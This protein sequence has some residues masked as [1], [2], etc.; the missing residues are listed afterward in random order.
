MGEVGWRVGCG[1][2]AL[3]GLEGKEGEGAVAEEVCKVTFKMSIKMQKLHF[4]IISVISHSKM[5]T[6]YADAN[7]LCVYKWLEAHSAI[8]VGLHGV[9]TLVSASTLLSSHSAVLRGRATA[10]MPAFMQVDLQEVVCQEFKCSISVLCFGKAILP[11]EFF[12]Y[13][14]RN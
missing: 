1:G 12:F 3:R 13:E 14:H 2:S 9:D 10:G 7:I 5:Y 6:F 4:H 8:L 11:E